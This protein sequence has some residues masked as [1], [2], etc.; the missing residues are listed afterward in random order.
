MILVDSSVLLMVEEKKIS[1]DEIRHEMTV[2][3]PCISEMQK[4]SRKKGKRGRAARVALMLIEKWKIRIVDC[5]SGCDHGLIECARKFNASVATADRK[6]IKALRE[7]GIKVL[8]M[9][10]KTIKRG[11]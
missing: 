10:G 4:L 11:D 2:L 8:N 3:Q 6:L 1:L 7:K 9:E 5:G